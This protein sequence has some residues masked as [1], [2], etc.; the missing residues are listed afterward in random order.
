L[1]AVVVALDQ[2]TKYLVQKSL[3]LWTGI[4]VIPGFFSLVHSLNKGSAFGFM[5]HAG[6]VWQP[7][8]FIAVTA[9]A[10]VIILNLLSKAPAGD[11]L[12]II[13]LGLILGGAVGNLIDRV[14]LGEV[15]DFLDFAIGSFHW[16]AF[17]VADMA[18]SL[19]S[20]ALI[21]SFYMRG[22]PPKK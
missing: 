14:R 4:D 15:V 22:R 10:I 7:Y 11:K 13:S 16:P 17:N 19:G 20:M 1:A 3:I 21:I 18:I 6:S 8:F 9:F 2:L 12:F 5:N